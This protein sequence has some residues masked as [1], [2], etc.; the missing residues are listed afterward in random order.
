MTCII[1][2]LIF[3]FPIASKDNIYVKWW[4]ICIHFSVNFFLYTICLPIFCWKNI[5]KLCR[6]IEQIERVK[7]KVQEIY[8]TVAGTKNIDKRI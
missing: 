5:F 6:G 3:N 8:K 4:D 2:I 7:V 1:L